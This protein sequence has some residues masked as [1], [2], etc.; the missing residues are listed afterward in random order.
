MTLLTRSVSENS[1][2]K[3]KIK[4]PP[5]AAWVS[6]D[7]SNFDDIALAEDKDVLVAFTAPWVGFGTSR[8]GGQG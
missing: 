2:V 6:L 8:D 1:G 4:P 3:S 7:S 5:P